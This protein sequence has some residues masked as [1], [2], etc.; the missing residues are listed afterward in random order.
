MMNKYN[1]KKKKKK[2][3]ENA[4]DKMW[5]YINQNGY[6]YKNKTYNNFYIWFDMIWYDINKVNNT[7]V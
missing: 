5:Q 7:I 3:N 4:K 2:K 6:I 1:K